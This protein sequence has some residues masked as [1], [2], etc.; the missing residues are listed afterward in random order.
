MFR[1][2]PKERARGR[3]GRSIRV[4][5]ATAAVL[6]VV[7]SG[8][9]AGD[10]QRLLDS[11]AV[12]P[13]L[14]GTLLPVLT[15]SNRSIATLAPGFWGADITAYY[16]LGA[17]QAGYLNQ[18]PLNYVRWP[19]GG[20]G[21]QYNFTANRIYSLG[22][23]YYSPP[24]GLAQFA[25]WCQSVGCRAIVELP[26]EIDEPA[27]AAYYVNYTESTLHF[28]P[29]YWEI[30]NEPALWA[31]F[32]IPW[33]KWNATQ[34][35]NA[36]PGSYAQVVQAYT[37]AI[38]AVDPSARI[39]GLPGVGT[40][41]YN[42]DVWV[43][44]TVALNGPNI[45][46]VAIHVYPA[47]GTIGR[48]SVSVAGFFGTLGDPSS[49]A[50]RVPSD[51][52]AI[53]AACPT[54]RGIQLFITE[55]GST[56]TGSPYAKY[57]GSANVVPYLA[58]EIAQAMLNS[59]DNVD[60]FAFQATYN[61]SLLNDTA[62]PSKLFTVYRTMLTELQPSILNFSLSSQPL[63]FLVVPA[64]DATGHTFSLFVVNANA[65]Y[66]GQLDLRHSGFPLLGPGT[67]WSW[68]ITS[69]TPSSVSWLVT[70]PAVWTVPPRGIL[71]LSIAP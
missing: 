18:T 20:P 28:H 63:H 55:M 35:L 58:A 21:D 12:D 49:L 62:V 66:T 26:A 11:A 6:L 60:L 50:V 29:A 22:G 14:P 42:E 70:A 56:T 45:S 9:W 30:G 68:D 15:V 10:P 47:G 59:V 32:G 7:A 41:G 37:A 71:V 33:A 31:H 67:A 39:V 36:T 69:P 13:A 19:G 17:T 43:R 34:H 27:T 8:V 51:R 1:R 46:A 44:A 61:G 24:A 5:L 57:S 53:S 52:A 23:A 54:C 65:S 40:G 25:T 3:R 38:H 48:G 16:A 64:R 4:G 2:N